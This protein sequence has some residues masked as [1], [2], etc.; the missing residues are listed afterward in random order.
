MKNTED[1]IIRY[2][3]C[4]YTLAMTTA[5][6]SVFIYVTIHVRLIWWTS[7]QRVAPDSAEFY[8]EGDGNK[9]E[10]F[11]YWHNDSIP[12]DSTK[13]FIQYYFDGKSQMVT[14]LLRL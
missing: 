11:F 9:I 6:C 12:Q 8:W 13:D 10:S 3:V 2:K 1:N 14:H 5:T 4:L 7:G